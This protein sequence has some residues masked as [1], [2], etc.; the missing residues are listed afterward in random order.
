MGPPARRFG[1]P[2]ALRGTA[3]AGRLWLMSSTGIESTVLEPTEAFAALADP[4]RLAIVRELAHGA[5]CVCDLREQ[6]PV[7]ANLLS[8]HLKVL[9]DAGLVT[10]SRQGRWISYALDADGL[11]QLRLEIPEPHAADAGCC[12]VAAQ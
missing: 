5:R 4:T 12:E 9:R 11:A 8:Y 1:T 6:V 3:R 2:R 10:A 7:A